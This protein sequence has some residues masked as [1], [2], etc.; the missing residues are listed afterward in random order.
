VHNT[1]YIT[2]SFEPVD[3]EA[4]MQEADEFD[5]EEFDQFINAQVILPKGNEYLLGTVVQWKQDSQG[6]PI[7]KQC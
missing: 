2:P 6:N 5:T 1:D 7:G 4:G 3:P